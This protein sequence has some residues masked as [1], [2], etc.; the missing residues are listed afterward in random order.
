MNGGAGHCLC[1]K[2]R[3]AFSGAPNWQGHCHCESCRRATGSGMASFLGVSDGAWRWTGGTPA[4]F[5]SSPGVRRHFCPHCGTPM[6]Y[7]SDRWPGEIH[8]HAG[9][10]DDPAAFQPTAHDMAHERLPWVMLNDGLPRHHT[11]RR[12]GPADDPAPVLHLIRTA[13]ARMDGRIDPPS[14][15]HRLTTDAMRQIARTAEIWVIEDLGHVIATVTLSPRADSLHVGKLAVSDACR[16]QGL[17]RR[18]IELAGDR[19]RALGLGALELHTRVEL[20][21][22][23]A[24]FAHLGFRETA[25]T[26]HP[27]YARPTSITFRKPLA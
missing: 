21:E 3:Y 2:V 13:F 12:I 27:G 11:P 26:A 9:T 8:F 15:A 23:H 1:G 10:L 14:S 5:A 24:V 4:C 25:R 17:A 22:N 20:T 7:A 18:L 16:G 19:A 6:A